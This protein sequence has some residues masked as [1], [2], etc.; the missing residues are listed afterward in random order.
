M[1]PHQWSRCLFIVL[2]VGCMPDAGAH[3]PALREA[4]FPAGSL[5]AL[6]S[7]TLMSVFLLYALGISRLWH[8][9][10]RGAGVSTSSAL[11]FVA[12]MTVLALA[13][14]SPLD[15]LAA[16]LFSAHMLQH[17]LMMLVA[18]PL[19]VCGNPLPVMTWAFSRRGRQHIAHVANAKAMRRT[20][21]AL[22]QPLCAWSV[23]AAALWAWHTPRLFTAGLESDLVHAMQ[24]LSF[25]LSALLF[26]GAL[27]GSRPR[28]HGMAIPIIL[29][30]A[31]HTGVLGALLTFSAHAWYPAYSDSAQA[32]G[33]SALQDQ[34]LGGLIMWVPAGFLFV[35]AGLVAA[36]AIMPVRERQA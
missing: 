25:V 23:H 8:R 10:Y 9:A 6:A 14:L 32:W 27:I 28:M 16:E 5:D 13:M 29:S 1:S 20:W 2:A 12:G 22:T 15:A 36:S 34:Q 18:A 3:A 35:F 11:F 26:W 24:H 17:E 31:I 7:A 19:I 4:F 21:H 30:T 33:L